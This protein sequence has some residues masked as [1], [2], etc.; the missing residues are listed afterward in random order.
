M[1][2]IRSVTLL[3]RSSWQNPS[4]GVFHSFSALGRCVVSLVISLY[5]P[6]PFHYV[7]PWATSQ[8]L[9][10]LANLH[11]MLWWFLWFP[12]ATRQSQSGRRYHGNNWTFGQ[13]KR[14]K[15]CHKKPQN[16]S[17]SQATTGVWESLQ[18]RILVCSNQTLRGENLSVWFHGW[19]P[20][21][22]LR[23]LRLPTKESIERKKNEEEREHLV[24][25]SVARYIRRLNWDCVDSGCKPQVSCYSAATNVADTHS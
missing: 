21:L 4:R 15:N 20:W 17:K 19:L 5:S 11:S 24:R 3:L 22:C 10:N 12:W 9:D 16:A 2:N 6:G 18:Q 8:G 25:M 14:S 23:G 7:Q 13:I 1:Q